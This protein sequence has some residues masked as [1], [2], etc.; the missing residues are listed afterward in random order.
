MKYKGPRSYQSKDMANVN[1]FCRQTNG[2]TDKWTGQN[3]EKYKNRVKPYER[4][5]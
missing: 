2:R 3:T 5:I 4:A 1:V